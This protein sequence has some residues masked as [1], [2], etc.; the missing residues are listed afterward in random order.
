MAG[1]TPR[2]N[3]G[4]PQVTPDEREHIGSRRDP[5]ERPKI[6]G[7]DEQRQT[8]EKAHD[9][10]LADSFPTSDPPSTIPDPGEDEDAA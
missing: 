10:T 2:G 8:K 7:E 3:K 9:K 4:T 5:E 6:K 1:E